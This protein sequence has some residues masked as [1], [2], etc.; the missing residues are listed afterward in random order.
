MLINI[1]D[2]F[3]PNIRAKSGT[4]QTGLGVNQQ[5][6]RWRPCGSGGTHLSGWAPPSGAKIHHDLGTG[7]PG[8]RLCQL[9]VGP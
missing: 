1:Q 2:N 7:I 5:L 3:E 8:S 4:W 6:V 9:D